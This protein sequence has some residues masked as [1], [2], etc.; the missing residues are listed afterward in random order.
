[1]KLVKFIS[2]VLLISILAISCKTTKNLRKEQASKLSAVYDSISMNYF[3]YR[4]LYIKSS[5][6]YKKD[7]KSL[8]LKTSIKILKDSL[9]IASLSPGLGIE[10]ARIKFTKDS[11]FIMDRL[12]SHLTKTAYKYLADSLN[13]SVDYA[14]IQNILT[15]RLFIYPKDKTMDLKIQFVNNYIFKKQISDIEVYRKTLSNIE[16]LIVI[17]PNDYHIKESKVNEIDNKRFM[18]IKFLGLFSDEF[19]NLPKSISILSFSD[20][21]YTNINIDYLKVQ[22]DKELR[23][24]F[25]I[26]SKYDVSV[27]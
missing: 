1:M 19:N 8:K 13:I 15:N 2:I 3:D 26:P 6:K 21:K 17:D 5:V 22:K 7:K 24:S 23:F 20:N 18:T 14:D 9:I 25:K 16:Q 4:T 11:V 27:Y 10:A 12:S